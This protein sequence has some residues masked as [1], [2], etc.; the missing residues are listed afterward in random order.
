MSSMTISWIVFACLFG[1]AL[2]GMF[3]RTVLPAHHLSS[4]SKDVVKLGM[5]LIGTMGALL[6]GLLV[7]SA[8]NSYD[9]EKSAFT[10]MSTKIILL[11][12]LMAHYGPETKEARDLLRRAVIRV[13]DQIWPEDSSRPAQLDPM[14]TGAEVII[15][16]IQAL[17]PQNDAQRSL[18]GQALSIIT[19]LTQ[20]RW[21]MFEQS[22]SSISMPLVVVV[23]FW[24]TVLFGSFGLY[25][26]PN[27]TVIATL[28]VCALS[29]SGALFLILELDQPFEGML[30]IPSAPLRNA[31]AHLGK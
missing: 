8:K 25:A 19:D 14:A 27:A 9:T 28:F 13:L 30:Q 26:P 10:Q 3:I 20:T 21:L 5:G 24:L 11:D 4:E 23:V 1:G 16:K 18:K 2:L 15:D 22:S 29:V 12:R 17:A 6:L 31:L 7:A